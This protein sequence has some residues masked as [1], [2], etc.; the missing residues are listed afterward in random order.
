MRDQLF[1]DYSCSIDFHEIV[2]ILKII[3][4]FLQQIPENGADDQG[5][6]EQAGGLDE[7]GP[8]IKKLKNVRKP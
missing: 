3:L 2:F 4:L 7:S 6:T 8:R 5:V 1:S